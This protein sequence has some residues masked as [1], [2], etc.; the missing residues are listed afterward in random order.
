[1]IKNILIGL[2]FL[3][4]VMAGT[5][6]SSFKVKKVSDGLIIRIDENT[7]KLQ[8]RKDNI[9]RVIYSA[10]EKQPMHK[11][12]MI[13][14]NKKK[15]ISWD[16]TEEDDFV[17][18]NTSVMTA[19]VDKKT[20]AVTFLNKRNEVILKEHPEFP[21]RCTPAVVLDENTYHLEQNFIFD[22]HEAI[23]GLGQHQDG[24]MNYRGHEIRLV[25]VNTIACVPFFLSTK[26][27]GILW[28][29][30]SDTRFDNKTDENVCKLW[31][32]V[33]DAIDYYF[34][35]GNNMDDL[36][37]G[38]RDLTGQAPMF[39]KWAFGYWQSK[40]RYASGEELLKTAKKFRELKFPIDNIIQDWQYWGKLGW[41]ALI[42]DTAY[43]PKPEEMLSDLHEDNFHVMISVW[44]CFGN[45]TRI[46]KEL[47]EN[48]LLFPD[49]P[50][51]K[52]QYYDPYSAKGREIFW[53][54]IKSGLFDKGIDAWWLDATE[55]EYY[56]DFYQQRNYERLLK[57]KNTSI[58]TS[59]RYLNPYSLATTQAVY[60]GQRKN[61]SDKRV[62][63]LTRSA[64]AGLQRNA[65]ATWSGDIY[66][67]WNV[68]RNQIAAGLNFCMSG[69]PYWTTDIGG[70]FVLPE[71]ISCEDNNYKELYLR[72]FQYGAFCPLF[73]SHGTDT[74]REPWNFG[75]PDSWIY[76][77]LLKY[78]NLRYRLL[79]YIYSLSWKVTNNDYTIMR[80]LPMDFPDDTNVYHINDQFMFGNQFL[81]CPVTENMYF[82]YSSS[83]PSDNLF[84]TNKQSGGLTAEYFKG[85]NFENLLYTKVDPKIYYK[86][87][88]GAP[89]NCPADSFSVRWTGEILTN[90]PGEHEFI[91]QTTDGVRLWIDGKI[92]IDGWDNATRNNYNAKVKLEAGKKYSIKLE[93]VEISGEARIILTIF[94]PVKKPEPGTFSIKNGKYRHVYLPSGCKWMDFW[95]GKSYEGGNS[96]MAN[97]PF[98]I[99]PLFVKAGSIIPMGPFIQ[100][101]TEKSPDPLEIRIYPGADGQFTLYEDENDN[102]N[103]EKGMYATIDF[104]WN[105]KAQM[106]VID[107]R[108][109]TYPGMLKNRTFN[110]VVVR[111]NHGIGENPE[112]KPDKIILYDGN[113]ISVK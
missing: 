75:D 103:Y 97:A 68:Y 10:D 101:S 37:A 98:D 54:H 56:A 92:V 95:N 106:L 51:N 31:S 63:I 19:K 105:D 94:Q 73:R 60:E 70:F 111:E 6:C 15:N 50:Y 87:R 17:F 40:E 1:M 27:Y 83:I 4:Y 52:G 41:N 62:F 113:R 82:D 102:Y 33:G 5:A 3:T 79:P 93:Y 13:V 57:I 110:I 16:M 64:F 21:H 43:F 28:D 48:K 66:A 39:G 88:I 81:V 96:I 49:I 109:G 89:D 38:Y 46:H 99:M 24:I 53:N 8:V 29:N 78:A 45:E 58:G 22:E 104:S 20:G 9:I 12:L 14:E 23:F 86:W 42:F 71:Y 84:T 76:Q 32:E 108:N 11:S 26:K 59:A 2:L 30:Y 47:Q 74:P 34:I 69:I 100:H 25:Q 77:S 112:L 80:G 90:Y 91:I 36:I 107:N 85:L 18:L 61:T 55:P 65:A 67:G 44:S 35:Y 72:W 7:L